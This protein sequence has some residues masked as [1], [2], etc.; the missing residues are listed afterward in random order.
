MLHVRVRHTE[1]EGR[2]EG[3]RGRFF[4]P[5]VFCVC[6]FCVR[7]CVVCLLC[8]CVCF[9]LLFNSHAFFFFFVLVLLVGAVNHRSESSIETEN[10]FRLMQKPIDEILGE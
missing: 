9:V 3:E 5:S 7:F 10:R 6:A 2:G 4:V 8:A 1:Q